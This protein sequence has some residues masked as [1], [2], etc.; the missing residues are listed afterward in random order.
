M[1]FFI[2]YIFHTESFKHRY[3]ELTNFAVNIFIVIVYYLIGVRI[4]AGYFE[5]GDIAAIIEYARLPLFFLMMAQMVMLTLPRA[6]ECCVRV[7]EV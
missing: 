6:M 1:L 4:T 7:G 5:I 2:Y 3:T